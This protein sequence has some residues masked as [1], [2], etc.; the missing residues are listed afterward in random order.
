MSTNSKYVWIRTQDGSPTLW[1]NDIGEPFRSVKGAFH[2][3]LIVFVK[4]AIE[5]AK[6]LHAENKQI[7][8]GEFGLGAGTNWVFFSVIAKYFKIP[9]K[10]FAVEKDT[11]AFEMAKIKWKEEKVFLKKKIEEHLDLKIEMQLDD[12]VEPKIFA[13]LEE[14]TTGLNDQGLKNNIWFHDP[15]GSGV[16]PDG[17]SDATLS[18]CSESWGK[19]FIGLSYACNGAFQKSLKSIGLETAVVELKSPPLKKEALQF[20]RSS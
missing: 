13:S 8:V 9:F 7:T 14:F 12:L 4:P 3:S 6:K 1:N 5:F 2:E 20:F 18:L 19:P 15:F 17:Y 16:N 10:Y 11:D